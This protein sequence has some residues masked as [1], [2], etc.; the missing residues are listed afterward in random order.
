MSN[1][2]TGGPA[3][4]V[5]GFSDMTLRDYF[6]AKAMIGIFADPHHDTADIGGY[7]QIANYAYS[8]ADAML[9]ARK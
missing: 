3:F 8:M 9:E 7:G 2:E 1:K 5:P 4:L 6:A